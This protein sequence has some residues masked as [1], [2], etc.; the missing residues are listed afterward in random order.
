MLARVILSSL[1]AL[2]ANIP[3]SERAELVFAAVSSKPS[4]S[5]MAVAAT[6]NAF[7]FRKLCPVY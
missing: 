2:S 7:N 3:F 1:D 5:P 6:P 4:S